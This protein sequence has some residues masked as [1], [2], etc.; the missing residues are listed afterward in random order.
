M[1]SSLRD[2]TQDFTQKSL[3]FRHV[4]STNLPD[5]PNAE[6]IHTFNHLHAQNIIHSTQPKVSV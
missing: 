6:I 3:L 4:V 5:I 2:I 1:F